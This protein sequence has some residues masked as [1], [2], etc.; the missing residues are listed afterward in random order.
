[1][2]AATLMWIAEPGR[3][4]EPLE[5]CHQFGEIVHFQTALKF[6]YLKAMSYQIC[7]MVQALGK[8]PNQ[9][10]QVFVNRCLRSIFQI[11]WPNTMDLLKMTDMQQIDVIIKRHKWDS[12]GHTV[13]KDES[14]VARLCNGILWMVLGEKRRD[15]VRPAEELWK[16]SAR[17]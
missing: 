13:R 1:M 7:C 10:Q 9:L 11:Y 5:Y 17:I 12:I 3:L 4:R 14:S 2:V 6:A 16:G 8:P 15:L